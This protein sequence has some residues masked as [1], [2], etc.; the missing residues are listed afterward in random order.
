M[1]RPEADRR[2]PGEAALLIYQ[3]VC[4]AGLA[5]VLMAQMTHGLGLVDLLLLLLGLLGVAARLRAAPVLVLILLAFGQ[6]NQAAFLG[7]RGWGLRRAGWS[8]HASDIVLCCGTFAYVAG[9]LRLQALTS[10]I[11]PPDRRQYEGTPRRGPLGWFTNR[12][13][14]RRRAARLVTAAE[15]IVFLLTLP[16]WAVLAQA[17]WAWLSTRQAVLGLDL[18]T[19]LLRFLLVTWL[20]AVGGGVTAAGFAQWRRRTMAPAEAAMILQDVLWRETRREQ[21]RLQ[22][23]LAW[24]RLRR[25]G[26]KETP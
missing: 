2:E 5:L 21:R 20:L 26:R 13:V 11:L 6:L 15:L 18:P 3:V 9:H 8:F 1:N 17:G 22:R 19:P 23:W 10:Y 25:A 16:L 24:S 12:P 4:L 7:A 14:R